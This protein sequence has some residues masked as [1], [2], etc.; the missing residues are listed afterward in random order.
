MRYLGSTDACCQRHMCTLA[1]SERPEL[2]SPGYWLLVHLVI[3]SLESSA[4]GEP[5]GAEEGILEG[6]CTILEWTASSQGLFLHFP[7]G[8]HP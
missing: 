7:C 5:K 6:S 8:V 4:A 3:P 2:W 1:G